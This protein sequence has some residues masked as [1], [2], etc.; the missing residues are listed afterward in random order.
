VSLLRQSS[1]GYSDRFLEGHLS[2][3]REQ[4]SELQDEIARVSVSGTDAAALGELKSQ[5]AELLLVLDKA[6][7]QELV[8]ESNKTSL[9]TLRLVRRRL[10]ASM[11]Q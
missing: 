11:P 3:L 7:T 9:G 6:E 1:H 2:Y 5:T 4:G 10:E 8:S